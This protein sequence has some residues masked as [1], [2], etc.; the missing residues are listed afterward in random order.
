[1]NSLLISV[2]GHGH[3]VALWQWVGVS[4][5]YGGLF[6]NIRTRYSNSTGGVHKG[7]VGAGG[8]RTG[9]AEAEEVAA[10][11]TEAE[12]FEEGAFKEE[13]LLVGAHKD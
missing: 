10:P 12:A 2:V 3:N 11:R 5:V 4:C 7:G 6:L 13:S 1:M 8:A 9:E